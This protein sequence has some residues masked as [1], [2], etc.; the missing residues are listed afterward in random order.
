MGVSAALIDEM[1]KAPFDSLNFLTPSQLSSLRLLTSTAQ[2]TLGLVSMDNCTGESIAA[3]CVARA[4]RVA[5]PGEAM[6][7]RWMRASGSCEPL[8]PEWIAARGVITRDTPK[9]LRALLKRAGERKLPVVLDSPG[10]DFDAAIEL[11]RLIR[12]RGLDT[13]VA[14]PAPEAC[15]ATDP[16]CGKPGSA[17]PAPGRLYWFGE[18][19]H[20]CLLVLG[21]GARRFTDRVNGAVFPH[22]A[23]FVS[24][25]K[26]APMTTLDPYFRE[27]SLDPDLLKSAMRANPP[28]SLRLAGD[29]GR[30][31]QHGFESAG[32]PD[33]IAGLDA[34]AAATPP[35]NC[36]MRQRSP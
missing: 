30:M 13:A 8:C 16:G 25:G 23:S 20:E 36:A 4:Q 26:A 6:T 18:C 32:P 9:Q 34:C 1:R 21:A 29:A 5:G 2:S 28:S 7:L 31:V 10:G 12:A 27:M 33:F 15:P 14:E 11:G 19:S 17:V 35:A 3:N 24:N 22:P